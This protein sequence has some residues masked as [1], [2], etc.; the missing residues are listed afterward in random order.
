MVLGK[1]SWKE[2]KNVPNAYGDKD[3]GG[4]FKYNKSYFEKVQ[5]LTNFG[6]I[7]AKN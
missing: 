5:F 3:F 7:L 4:F 1:D 2:W 6:S